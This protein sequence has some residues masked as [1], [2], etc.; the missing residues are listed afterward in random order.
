[1]PS[2]IC[3]SMTAGPGREA[4]QDGGEWLPLTR[5]A[6]CWFGQMIG[7]GGELYFWEDVNH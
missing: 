7:D 3:V 1:M 4:P 2:A 5:P 6:L